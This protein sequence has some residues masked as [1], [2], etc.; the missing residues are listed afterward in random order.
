MP[1]PPRPPWL[2]WQCRTAAAAA[3]GYPPATSPPPSGAGSWHARR[4]GWRAQSWRQCRRRAG[5]AATR[6]PRRTQV[7]TVSAIVL[8]CHV[9]QWFMLSR[10]A[11]CSRFAAKP[12][13]F[14]TPPGPMHMLP[15]RGFVLWADSHDDTVSS[16]RVLEGGVLLTCSARWKCF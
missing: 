11:Q 12:P 9:G 8:K 16:G 14:L 15:K 13:M 7:A 6:R 5:G 1:P 2:R 3:P 4:Q 10:V